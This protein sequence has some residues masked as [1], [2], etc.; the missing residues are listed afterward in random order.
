M[1]D[2]GR[3]DFTNTLRVLLEGKPADSKP[4]IADFQGTAATQDAGDKKSQQK[5]EKQISGLLV[6]FENK[7]N[8]AKEN[9]RTALANCKKA[10]E[11]H[12][13]NTAGASI[14]NKATTDAAAKAA[15]MGNLDDKR[16]GRLATATPGS[17]MEPGQSR[18]DSGILKQAT[19]GD[20]LAGLPATTKISK[21]AGSV[22]QAGDDFKALGGK[23][24][25]SPTTARAGLSKKFPKPKKK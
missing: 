14:N 17:Q 24:G 19:F 3:N 8:E 7:W 9:I 20:E 22:K 16:A 1:N 15:V 5:T 13:A 2:F 12:Q 10:V 6:D 23:G 25:V 21:A 11:A 18:T 4:E